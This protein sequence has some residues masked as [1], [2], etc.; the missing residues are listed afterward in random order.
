M[1]CFIVRKNNHHNL[2]LYVCSFVSA[3]KYLIVQLLIATT[4]K[5]INITWWLHWHAPVDW[6][7]TKCP[8][9]SID[10]I[11]NWFQLLTVIDKK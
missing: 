10:N 2:F 11:D 8:M 5:F 4:I 3:K 1:I 9:K 6:L 7:E